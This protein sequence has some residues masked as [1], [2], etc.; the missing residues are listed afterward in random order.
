MN[1]PHE[2][3]SLRKAFCSPLFCNNVGEGAFFLA[4]FVAFVLL[5]LVA[6]FVRCLLLLLEPASFPRNQ[7]V[8]LCQVHHVTCHFYFGPWR[9]SSYVLHWKVSM[10]RWGEHCGDDEHIGDDIDSTPIEQ[11]ENVSPVWR[12]WNLRTLRLERTTFLYIDGE[13]NFFFF[14]T[15]SYKLKRILLCLYSLMDLPARGS[16]PKRQNTGRNQEKKERKCSCQA[17]NI[18]LVK[19]S[20]RQPPQQTFV[21]LQL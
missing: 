11:K 16:P 3:V 1:H 10:A 6:I 12:F 15:T 19:G 4:L 18:G 17:R 7:S 13:T 14:S 20:Q 2:S 21:S 8:P 9:Q 5:F